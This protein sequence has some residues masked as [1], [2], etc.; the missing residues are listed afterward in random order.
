MIP[1]S[2][3]GDTIP[4]PK[5]N[6]YIIP[7][8]IE[9]NNVR[10]GVRNRGQNAQINTEAAIITNFNPYVAYEKVNKADKAKT[11]MGINKYGQFKVGNI[12]AFGPG[13]MLTQTFGN[14]VISFA[15]DAK[16]NQL[17]KDDAAHG[18]RG[19][20]VP[21]MNI[22]T[23]DGKTVRG[24]LNILTERGNTRSDTYGWVSGGRV[25]LQAG[26]ETRLVSGSINDIEKQLLD[27]KARH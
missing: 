3:T 18:N 23:D 25:V 17:W 2:Y 16:G 19:R 14:K 15:K 22:M 12:D 4:V 7:E 11:Y 10:L 27:L 9:L 21:V 13:D 26:N 1:S 8:S 5:S 20:N 6:R 24:S